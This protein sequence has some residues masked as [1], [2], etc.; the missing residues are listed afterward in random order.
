MQVIL[1]L[2]C[3]MLI[4]D[5]QDRAMPEECASHG[6]P[7]SHHS[8]VGDGVVWAEAEPTALLAVSFPVSSSMPT[9]SVAV[10]QAVAGQVLIP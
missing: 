7:C 2:P 8:G 1:L 6:L 4:V 9:T 3:Y 5:S 10:G